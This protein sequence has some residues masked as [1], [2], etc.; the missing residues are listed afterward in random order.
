MLQLSIL[1]NIFIFEAI[2]LQRV[3][4]FNKFGE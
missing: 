1:R 2:Q 4:V 3:I